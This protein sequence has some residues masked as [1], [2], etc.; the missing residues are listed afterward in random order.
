[1]FMKKRVNINTF[2]IV[3]LIGTYTGVN[4]TDVKDSHTI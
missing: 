2:I 3:K 1:M 4:N